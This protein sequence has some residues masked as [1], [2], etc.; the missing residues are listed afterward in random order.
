MT[1]WLTE[2]A[3]KLDEPVESELAQYGSWGLPAEQPVDLWI[4]LNAFQLHLIHLDTIPLN[5][6]ENI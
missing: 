2:R 3:W 6:Y 5:L 1:Q 4:L